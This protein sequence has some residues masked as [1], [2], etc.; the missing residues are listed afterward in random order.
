[1]VPYETTCFTEFTDDVM[2]PVFEDAC[3]QYVIDDDGAS[4]Y[5]V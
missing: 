2:R 1:M 5:G 4:V 3:G